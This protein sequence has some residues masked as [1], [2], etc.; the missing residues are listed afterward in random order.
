[1]PET[2]TSLPEALTQ[3]PLD[4]E[5]LAIKL[6]TDQSFQIPGWQTPDLQLIKSGINSW[7]LRF[8]IFRS[9]PEGATS[10]C[11]FFG[12]GDSP[13]ADHNHLKGILVS[14]KTDG[15]YKAAW[16]DNHGQGIQPIITTHFSAGLID[17][18]DPRE[19]LQELSDEFNRTQHPSATAISEI[20]QTC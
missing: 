8:E 1:M 18:F 12:N 10:V 11:F 16:V 17:L 20:N 14:Q 19:I 13:E 2:V 15:K 6:E 4:L 5:A 9:T 3:V 7:D